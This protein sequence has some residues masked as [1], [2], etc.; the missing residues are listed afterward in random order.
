MWDIWPEFR[1]WL[2]AGE[3]VALA[4]V[5]KAARPSPRGM[6]ATMAIHRDGKQFIGSVSAGCVEIE[7][8]EAARATLADGKSRYAEFGGEHGFPW[9]V[10]MSCGGTIGVRIDRME[11]PAEGIAAFSHFL[12]QFTPGLLLSQDGLH[13]L[14]DEHGGVIYSVGDWEEARVQEALRCVEPEQSVTFVGSSDSGC[15]VRTLERPRRLFVIG[16]VHISLH[17]VR[18]ARACGYQTIVIDPREAYAQAS[19]FIETPHALVHGWPHK[20]LPAF[21]P[22]P[23]DSAAVV[24]HDPKID[25]DALEVLLN[26]GC[27]YIGALG[28][29]KNHAA[30]IRRLVRVLD[31]EVVDRIHGPIGLDIGSETP[32]EIAVSIMAEIIAHRKTGA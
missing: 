30:R 3:P 29:R 28:S 15:L 4:T 20:V 23:G 24:T 8:L 1:T 14:L 6:G 17:L 19:R 18:M 7:V 5:V 31:P 27:G 11:L 9:E 26:S 21:K 12:S 32:A 25:D 10:S 22:G 13:C 16:A 2:Q